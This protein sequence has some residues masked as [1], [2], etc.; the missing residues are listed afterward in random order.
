MFVQAVQARGVA[1]SRQS[2]IVYAMIVSV[3]ALA[4]REA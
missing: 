4:F 1:G 2:G 3:Q